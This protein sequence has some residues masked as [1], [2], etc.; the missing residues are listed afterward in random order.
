[1]AQQHTIGTHA[2]T[3][4]EIDGLMTVV[5][6]RTPVVRWDHTQI[7]LDHGGYMTATTKTRMN[8]ASNQFRLGYYV[9]QKNFEWF[10]HF[11]DREIAFQGNQVT[12]IRR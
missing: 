8:Q 3:V 12:L 1:M 7:I 9:Y 10:V 2:T 5:Y 6:H 11:E 4:S